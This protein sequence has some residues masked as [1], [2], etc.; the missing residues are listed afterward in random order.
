MKD[1]GLLILRLTF[2]GLLAGHGGQ[3]LFGWFAGPGFKGTTGWLE[4]MGIRPGQ[5]WAALAGGSEFGG[6]VLTA[7]GFLNPIGPLATMGA[8]GMATAKV[9]AGKPIWV[10]S[11][12]AELPVLNMAVAIALSL[13]QPGKYSLDNA[14]HLSLPRRLI[15]I[16]GLILTAGAI[17]YGMKASA[18]PQTA[19]QTQP[20]EEPTLTAGAPESPAAQGQDSWDGRDADQPERIA[21][22]ELQAG[23]DASH[24]V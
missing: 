21:G 7:L 8:M 23:Q 9:H 13:L 15:L 22:A 12:G 10:T 17:A 2:G 3:K 4:S 6:G 1:L 14:L 24:P 18:Q 20:E 11:G 16:P 5:P 19:E